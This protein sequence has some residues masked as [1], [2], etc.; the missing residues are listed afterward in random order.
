MTKFDRTAFSTEVARLQAL[1]TT[2]AAERLVLDQVAR[3]LASGAA[4]DRCLML[5]RQGLDPLAVK[6]AL[7]QPV[8]AWFA[9]T[10]PYQLGTRHRGLGLALL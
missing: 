4:D 9:T 5:L 2:T 1:S 10:A 6:Q 8:G 3:A 7:S